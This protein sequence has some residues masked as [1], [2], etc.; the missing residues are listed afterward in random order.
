[1][2]VS[3]FAYLLVLVSLVPVFLLVERGCV[4]VAL[5]AHVDLVDGL[6]VALRPNQREISAVRPQFRSGRFLGTGMTILAADQA[7]KL[8]ISANRGSRVMSQYPIGRAVATIEQD[9]HHGPCYVVS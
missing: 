3:V 6:L 1:M 8:T 4:L 2:H 7:R 5:V 9:P